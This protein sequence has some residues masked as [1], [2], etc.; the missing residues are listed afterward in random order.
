MP[1]VQRRWLLI[2]VDQMVPSFP[3][4]G[5]VPN[6][7]H[8]AIAVPDLEVAIRALRLSRPPKT[9]FVVPMPGR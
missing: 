7:G 9:P 3:Q 5:F 4:V 6:L 8:R 2:R 1:V